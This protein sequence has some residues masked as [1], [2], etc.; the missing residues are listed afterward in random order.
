MLL[1]VGADPRNAHI[2]PRLTKTVQIWL[3]GLEMAKVLLKDI[4]DNPTLE[5]L[6]CEFVFIEEY[7]KKVVPND[8]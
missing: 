4:F 7:L 6:I 3:S 8:F 5:N 2:S 1:F